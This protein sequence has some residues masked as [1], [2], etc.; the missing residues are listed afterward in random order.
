MKII[1]LSITN[2]QNGI[3]NGLIIIDLSKNDHVIAFIDL[4]Y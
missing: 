2:R 4:N 1:D 3:L